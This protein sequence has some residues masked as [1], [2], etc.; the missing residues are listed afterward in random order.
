MRN[1]KKVVIAEDQTLVRQGLRALLESEE[2]LKVVAEAEDGFEAIRCD[3]KHKPD[4]VLM[5]LAMPKM[6]GLSALKD[7]KNRYSNQYMLRVS[8]V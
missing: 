3:E 6:S 1:A 8:M 5:D 4:L 2:K 7:I